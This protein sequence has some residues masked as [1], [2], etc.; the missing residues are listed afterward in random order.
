[1]GETINEI[2]WREREKVWLGRLQAADRRAAKAEAELADTRREVERLTRERDLAEQNCDPAG[3]VRE[4]ILVG[5]E[6]KALR[7]LV[8][9]QKAELAQALA[10]SSERGTALSLVSGALADA[11]C[12]VGPAVEFGD[13]VR[14]LAEEL[15][16]ARE[17]AAER[18]QHCRKLAADFAFVAKMKDETQ[19]LWEHEKDR[20]DAAVK[21]LR[22]AREWMDDAS[23]GLDVTMGVMSKIDAFLSPRE[24][25][26]E[27][28]IPV[29][30]P[31]HRCKVCGALW[32][33]NEDGS[34]SLLSP[35]AGQCCD[36]VVMS[37]QIE[38]LSQP[39]PA[40][41]EDE[42]EKLAQEIH[43]AVWAL[44]ERYHTEDD[45]KRTIA[46]ILR[47]AL[48]AAERKGLERAAT[49]FISRLDESA[50]NYNVLVH[51]NSALRAGLAWM[52]GWDADHIRMH[53]DAN[54]HK[55]AETSS[56]ALAEQPAPEKQP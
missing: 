56:S 50:R 23:R 14:K 28:A 47:A 42:A 31:T 37:E 39:A 51:E 24:G 16:Q 17:H 46:R 15:A 55:P 32:R 26:G 45:E 3:M 38:S 25:P 36:N 53:V 35:G 30:K 10:S 22:E 48:A 18:G 54:A 6:N 21:L 19:T 12:V 52:A 1:M 7:V 43:Q 11:D 27:K 40:D 8:G 44:Q 34:Y 20:A 13:Q 9:E 4:N 33:Q 29:Q 5:D 49:E 2:A 41:D